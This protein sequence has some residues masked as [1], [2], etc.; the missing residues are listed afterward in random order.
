MYY[1]AEDG[2]VLWTD[3]DKD[4]PSDGMWH[5][6]NTLSFPAMEPCYGIP[7][8]L[9]FLYALLNFTQDPKEPPALKISVPFLEPVLR[10]IQQRSSFHRKLRYAN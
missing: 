7:A 9:I 10:M 6:G 3:M 8:L 1:L 5:H 2:T 4:V